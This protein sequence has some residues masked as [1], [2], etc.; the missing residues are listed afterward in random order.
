MIF[1][2]LVFNGLHIDKL[3]ENLYK[4][5]NEFLVEERIW[6]YTGSEFV[7]IWLH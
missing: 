7:H 6:K 2:W 3:S 4:G 1:R 5:E